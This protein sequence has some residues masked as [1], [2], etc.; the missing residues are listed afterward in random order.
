[1]EDITDCTMEGHHGGQGIA[2]VGYC[3]DKEDSTLVPGIRLCWFA[4][5][6]RHPTSRVK[7]K[8]MVCASSVFDRAALP[9]EFIHCSS[10]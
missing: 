7:V 8:V 6:S 4:V 2:S 5:G 3:R 10:S 1:M 9:R